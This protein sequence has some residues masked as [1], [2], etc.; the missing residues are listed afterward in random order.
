MKI[1]KACEWRMLGY[2]E[3][4]DYLCTRKTIKEMREVSRG[5]VSDTEHS[6]ECT[7]KECPF[8]SDGCTPLWLMHPL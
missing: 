1:R 7:L 3:K 6:I 8:T 5:Q 2:K 4:N